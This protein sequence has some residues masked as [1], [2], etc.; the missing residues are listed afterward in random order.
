MII[1][2]AKQDDI[3][4]I[5]EIHNEDE[6]RKSEPESLDPIPHEYAE[7]LAAIDGDNQMWV[8]ER[9]GRVVGCFQLTFIR[10]LMRRGALI[11]QIES[12][13]VAREMRSQGIGEAMMR[14]A[15][16][17]ARKKKCLRVQLTS[18]KRRTRAHRFYERMGF[19]MSHEGMKLYLE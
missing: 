16:E 8:A 2:R 4:S 7:A 14:F 1:R 18:Q 17:E 13:H 12:V 3:R 10:H 15:V 5:L 9:D 6:F 11:A 19:V